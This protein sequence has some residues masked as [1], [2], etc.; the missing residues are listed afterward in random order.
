MIAPVIAVSLLTLFFLIYIIYFTHGI[1]Q[2]NPVRD[3]TVILRDD[4]YYLRWTS[5]DKG[6]INIAD[7]ILAFS[8]QNQPLNRQITSED[9]ILITNQ[10]EPVTPKDNPT[11]I[12]GIIISRGKNAIDSRSRYFDLSFPLK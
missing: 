6:N 5:V 12:R 1:V 8:G 3:V 7:Y 9:E 2:L 10:D 11:N 4:K